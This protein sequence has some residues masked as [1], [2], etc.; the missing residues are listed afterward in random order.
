MRANKKGREEEK[1]KEGELQNTRDRYLGPAKNNEEKGMASPT[2]LT[3]L[4]G[5]ID[6]DAK[7]DKEVD[8]PWMTAAK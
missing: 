4:H 2:P 8:T 6:G 5:P 3:Y 7:M 1:G